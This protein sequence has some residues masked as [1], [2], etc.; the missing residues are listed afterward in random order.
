MPLGLIAALLTLRTRC[1]WG[2]VLFHLLLIG[3]M[4]GSLR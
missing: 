4:L 2:A 1:I 3:A